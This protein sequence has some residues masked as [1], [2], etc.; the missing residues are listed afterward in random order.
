MQVF[1]LQALSYC[2]RLKSCF[3][4]VLE[5]TENIFFDLQCSPPVDPELK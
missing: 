1:V 4:F 2:T 3:Y 5:V